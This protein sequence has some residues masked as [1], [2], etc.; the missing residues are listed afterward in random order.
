MR[1]RTRVSDRLREGAPC[2]LTL[3]VDGER[4]TSHEVVS[5]DESLDGSRL[6]VSIDERTSISLGSRVEL[7]VD[8]AAR[9]LSSEQGGTLTEKLWC[10]QLE[11]HRPDPRTTIAASD[12]AGTIPEG[13]QPFRSHRGEQNAIR[14]VE[15]VLAQ[16]CERLAGFERSDASGA[17]DLR[18][19][20]FLQ[21]HESVPDFLR[22]VPL[23]EGGAVLW[24]RD[25]Y[26]WLLLGHGRTE[27]A[28]DLDRENGLLHLG[29]CETHDSLSTAVNH[30]DPDSL[31]EKRIV[32]RQEPPGRMAMSRIASVLEPS[33]GSR[34]AHALAG[35][36]GRV[37][38]AATIR[39]DLKIGS[40]VRFADGSL[41]TVE[42]IQHWAELNGKYVNQVRCVSRR[43]WGLG[44]AVRRAGYVGSFPAEVVAIDDPEGQGRV[45]VR[46]LEDLAGQPTPFIPML[47]LPSNGSYGVYWLPSVGD[48]VYVESPDELCPERMYVVPGARG[49]NQRVSAPPGTKFIALNGNTGIFFEKD[50]SMRIKHPRGHITIDPAG[51]WT[52]DGPTLRLLE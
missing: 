46:L 36:G 33:I 1:D 17:R 23:A 51:N 35:Q 38:D 6:S 27:K 12:P 10:R 50:G 37:Y 42:R 18:Q 39:P 40:Q 4:V 11:T 16:L 13:L 34:R 3:S 32:V 44:G 20:F 24:S 49:P 26:E 9:T 41:A 25:S 5:L 15:D 30:V 7:E 29:V 28:V 48:R 2:R 45:R 19:P 52:I 43:N 31:V 47:G 21:R 14:F 22:R 8:V